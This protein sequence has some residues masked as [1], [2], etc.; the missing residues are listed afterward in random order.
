[1]SKP[2]IQRNGEAFTIILS[3]CAGRQNNDLQSGESQNIEIVTSTPGSFLTE[4]D[5]QAEHHTSSIDNE[6]SNVTDG[7][8]SNGETSSD[9]PNSSNED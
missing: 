1:M 8:S 9:R 5:S 2:N 4:S 3:G 7:F 6:Q